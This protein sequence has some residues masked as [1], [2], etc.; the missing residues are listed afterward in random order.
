M[1]FSYLILSLAAF[2]LTIA[3][4]LH[5]EETVSGPLYIV[6][7]FDVAPTTAAESAAIRPRGKINRFISPHRSARY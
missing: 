4:P 2:A 1:R 7:Y 5:A 6:T 3:S